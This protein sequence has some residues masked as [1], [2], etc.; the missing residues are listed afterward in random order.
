[1]RMGGVEADDKLDVEATKAVLRRAMR[2]A[3]PFRRTIAA[4]LVFVMLSTLGLLLGPVIVGYGIDNGI[5]TGD[6]GVLRN[7]G[8]A[9]VL[10]V[11]LGYLTARQQYIFVNRAGEG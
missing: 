8:I 10:V 11:I 9:Y 6:R 3:K 4:A 7:A 2:M 1:M 5:T